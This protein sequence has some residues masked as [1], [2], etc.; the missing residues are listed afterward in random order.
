[1][2][3]KDLRQDID[4]C[5]PAGEALQ[6]VKD[7]FERVVNT[8][9]VLI[10]GL[11]NKG[12]IVVFNTHCE[13]VTGWTRQEAIGKDWFTN[14]VPERYRP[15]FGQVFKDVIER[16]EG[17]EYE[18][19]VLTKTGEERMIAWNNSIWRDASGE[20]LLVIGAGIDI[21]NRKVA[22]EKLQWLS[23][24]DGLT[25]IANRRYFEE[26]LDRE[27]RRAVRYAVPL[28]LIMCD[29][30]FFKAY[31]DTYG[32]LSGDDCLKQVVAALSATLKRPG[33]LV[34]RYGGEEFVIVLP[35]TDP[36]GAAHVAE[37]LRKQIE[38]LG[39]THINS[40]V[41]EHVTVSLGVATIVPN[42]EFSPA[43]LIFTADQALY[44]A[45]QSG[46]NRIKAADLK[47]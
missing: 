8:A 6:G 44:Q 19:P 33:D 20:A 30:D 26:Y 37:N 34:A 13:E 12:K 1:M 27:W 43:E 5:V 23:S 3:D 35:D 47:Q 38:G 45:K 16:Y 41:S 9:R 40:R 11:D 15:E 39:I 42:Q 32:H 17:H 24:M 4:L 18:N 2:D 7:F 36:R 29:I 25:G 31:N 46:R 21:T 28:S 10:V 14:F 22:E